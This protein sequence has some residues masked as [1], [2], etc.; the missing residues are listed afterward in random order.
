M[1]LARQSCIN[2]HEAACE[3]G[4]GQPA[5]STGTSSESE[6]RSG[7]GQGPGCHTHGGGQP[8]R[9]GHLQVPLQPQQRGHQDEDLRHFLEDF[10]VLGERDTGS[11][12]R[13]EGGTL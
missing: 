7:Q 8:R 12:G 11:G 1:A 2:S 9:Q 5:R 4:G 6:N 10:P 13:E 3:A